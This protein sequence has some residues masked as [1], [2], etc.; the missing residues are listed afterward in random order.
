L[1]GRAAGKR[2]RGRTHRWCHRTP[3]SGP[4][5]TVIRAHM[6]CPAVS[7]V[8]AL[9]V[10]IGADPRTLRRAVRQGT[11]RCHRPGQRRL[12]VTA[13]ERRYLRHHWG[14]LA[15]LRRAL[16]TE[17]RVRLAVL[18]G[19]VATGNVG[20]S[21]DIDILVKYDGD[22]LARSRLARRLEH[23]G[24]RRVHLVTLEQARLAAS[25]F[26]DV[27]EDGRVLVDRDSLLPVLKR[28]EEEVLVAA[29]AEENAVARRADEAV[30]AARRRLE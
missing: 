23:A 20:A 14:L 24:G 9:A 6:L 30:R 10:N 1:S 2:L 12:E 11:V 7:D 28:E 5:I 13:E 4:F 15:A 8:Q 16:R 3:A 17:V 29:R 22:P 25:L 18:Y 21:S 26:A 19:S 27:I